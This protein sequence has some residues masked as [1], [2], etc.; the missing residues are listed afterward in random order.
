MRKSYRKL[1]RND[2]FSLAEV[3]VT[4]VIAAMILLSVLTIYGNVRNRADSINQKL[5]EYILPNEILHR[6]AD[7]ID[8]IVAPGADAQITINNRYDNGFSTAQLIITSRIY[9][10]RNNQQIFEKVIWQSNYDPD[11]NRLMLYRSHSGIT[12]ED[13][14]L[15]Q[16]KAEGQERRMELFVPLCT[17]VSFFRIEAIRGQNINDKWSGDSLPGAVVV[18]ISFGQPVESP[19]G[20]FTVAEAE[21]VSR[22]IAV[23]RT[24]KIR[25]AFKKENVAL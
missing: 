18:T 16:Q 19:L 2:G 17:G 20:G 14:L 23:D 9:D 21:R 15:S 3:I 8:R 12:E 22:T 25:F 7:D 5:G 1:I 4:I 10:N 6:I 24:R 11:I 13:K